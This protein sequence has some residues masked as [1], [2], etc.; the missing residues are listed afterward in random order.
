MTLKQRAQ[1]LKT[2]IPAVFLALRHP[3]TPFLAKVL[4]AVTICYALSPI[5]LIP[6]FIPVLG[7]LDD[8]LLLPG[9]IALTVRLIPPT[10]FA[11]CREQAKSL[12]KEGRPKRWIF[13][14]PILLCWLLVLW[15]VAKAIWF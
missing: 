14:L 3:Q 8:V 15:L 1:Q 5:D 13:A 2:D 12:W 4:A 11:A 6:D 7:F 9:F 10:V